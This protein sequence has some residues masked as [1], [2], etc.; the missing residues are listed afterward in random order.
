MQ[1]M[2]KAIV[3]C[4]IKELQTKKQRRENKSCPSYRDGERIPSMAQ[5]IVVAFYL[6]LVSYFAYMPEPVPIHIII[7]ALLANHDFEKLIKSEL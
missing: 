3:S 7:I 1:H 5:M 2:P 4:K 6:T